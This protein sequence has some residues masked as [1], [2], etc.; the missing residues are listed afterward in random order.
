M[1]RSSSNDFI[2][3]VPYYSRSLPTGR[4]GTA[5]NFVE[6]GLNRNSRFP[7]WSPVDGWDF[8]VFLDFPKV[9]KMTRT[10]I[11]LPRERVVFTPRARHTPEKTDRRV[12][13]CRFSRFAELIPCRRIG[14]SRFPRFS[15]SWP[16][17]AHDH[18]VSSRESL[19]L[20]V[21]DKRPRRPTGASNFA[22]FLD[23]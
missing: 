20:P 19:L 14:L 18:C 11:G 22:V 12:E 1:P 13:V 3:V 15:E 4:H 5:R 6:T 8:V 16:Y 7:N 2:L 23:S 21:R 9:G 10:A 17:D